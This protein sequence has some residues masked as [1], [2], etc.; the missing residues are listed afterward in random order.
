[1]MSILLFRLSTPD[2]KDDI[3]SDESVSLF[4]VT[5]G[6]STQNKKIIL[7]RQISSCLSRFRYMFEEKS[8]DADEN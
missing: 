7:L 2:G 6:L 5:S 1:M 8:E 4:L 3:E